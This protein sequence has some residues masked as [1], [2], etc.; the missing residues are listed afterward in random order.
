MKPEITVAGVAFT[1]DEVVTAIVR[2]QGREIL[3]DRSD[4]KH[5]LGFRAESYVEAVAADNPAVE[6]QH[7]ETD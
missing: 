4:D 7:E 6:E 3:I 5:R 1:A 2:K